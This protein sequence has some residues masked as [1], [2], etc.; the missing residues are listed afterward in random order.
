MPTKDL[1]E[2]PFDEATIQKLD[3]FE[4]YTQEWLPTFIMS[5]HKKIY[6]FDFFAGPGYS[7]T[8]QEGSPIRILRQ[9][10]SQLPNI[11]TKGTQVVIIFNEYDKDKHSQLVKAID[12]FIDA[13]DILKRA[14]TAKNVI[15]P[16]PRNEDFD[17]L[18]SRIQ[19]AF[20]SVP[21]LMFLDQNGI[22]FL[23]DK[24]L[25]P[26]LNSKSTDFLYYVS[27]SYFNRFGE[28]DAFKTHLKL[29]MEEARKNPYKYIHRILLKSL[30]EK[31]PQTSDMMLYPFSIKKGSNIYGIIFGTSHIR[32]A[33]KFLR[34][35][36]GENEKN[37]EANFDIDDDVI[38]E[39][40]GLFDDD[41]NYAKE[42]TKIA[43]FK[44][45]VRQFVLEKRLKTNMDVYLFT[46][47]RGHIPQHSAEVLRKMKK[48]G[49][50]TYNKKSP[51]VSYDKTMNEKEREIIDYTVL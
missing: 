17:K 41:P 42:L 15:I 16:K 40:P 25:L 28:E 12:D 32:G 10:I 14:I 50:I 48:E 9:V 4:L 20:G 49:L 45:D 3:I 44:N 33:D 13:N 39:A 29:D 35:A 36:W 46:I 21:A 8:H 6:I 23:G 47:R 7:V 27:S 18:F 38:K 30:R 37:G 26:L 34:V 31:I 43:K 2:K 22:K 5:G 51:C 1:H 24:Y 19:K 11:F